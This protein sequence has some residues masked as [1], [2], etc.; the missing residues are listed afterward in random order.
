MENC[1]VVI[2]Q[3]GSIIKHKKMRK[4]LPA[5]MIE[6]PLQAK[7]LSNTGKLEVAVI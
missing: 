1:E 4:A 7:D 2:T 6:I 5:E 3:H